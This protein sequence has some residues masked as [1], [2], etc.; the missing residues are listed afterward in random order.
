MKVVVKSFQSTGGFF[1][2]IW[3]INSELIQ[4]GIWISLVRE[5]AIFLDIK[6]EKIL[7]KAKNI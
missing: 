4:T 7:Q 3:T 6:T 5:Q 1:F 2:S